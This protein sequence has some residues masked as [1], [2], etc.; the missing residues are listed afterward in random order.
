MHTHPQGRRTS[1]FGKALAN[2]SFSYREGVAQNCLINMVKRWLKVN[3]FSPM[4]YAALMDINGGALNLKTLS[5]IRTLETGGKKWVRNTLT[6]S[7]H[8]M[9]EAFKLTE[10]VG[11]ILAPFHIDQFPQGEAIRFDYAKLISLI[12][13]AFGIKDAALERNVAISCSI[14]GA[15]LTRFLSHVMG[16]FKIKDRAAID[17]LTKLP[18]FCGE[19]SSAQSR[20]LC[21]PMHLHMGQ[22]KKDK[23]TT[24]FGEMFDFFQR[25][26][27]PT[28]LTG[29]GDWRPFNLSINADM[30]AIW[31][32]LGRGGGARTNLRPCYCCAIHRDQQHIPNTKRCTRFCAGVEN[33]NWRCYHQVMVTDDRMLQMNEEINALKAAM[34]YLL[35]IVSSSRMTREDP[36]NCE[37]NETAKLDPYSIWFEPRKNSDRVDFSKLFNEELQIRGVMEPVG[38]LTSRREQL[39]EC[40]CREY[41]LRKLQEET[42]ASERPETAMF[43]LMQAVPCILHLENRVALKLLTMVVL[44]GISKTNEGLLFADVQ[45]SRERLSHYI[46]SIEKCMNETILGTVNSPAQWK[47]PYDYN[48]G[49]LGSITLEN[50]RVR[51]VMDQLELLVNLSIPD[52]NRKT[53][54]DR[55][56]PKY[57]AV[58]LQ[59]RCKVDWNTPENIAQFQLLVDEWFQDWIWLHGQGGITNYIHMLS[60]G[61]I[62]DYVFRW[63]NLYEHSQQGWESFNSLVKSFFFRRTG[64]GGGINRSRLRSIGRWLQRRAIWMC[65]YNEFSIKAFLETIDAG[66]QQEENF[67]QEGNDLEIAEEMEHEDNDEVF[68]AGQI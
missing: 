42:G 22:E 38:N 9:Q 44:E 64:H 21:F 40:L 20:L 18:I 3:F 10:R 17:P 43:L 13:S 41:R 15:N 29:L 19:A 16:G 28:S 5:L 23:Y 7:T 12:F 66:E 31:K 8:E 60:A 57:R 35:E 25:T 47:C 61:H 49:K 1:V 52:V 37:G 67:M 50:W 58:M 68:F 62:A 30:S 33:P 46:S 48:E 26:S 45:G 36:E 14:D 55:S 53:A 27:V 59:A 32:G 4:A 24:E 2:V 39:R 51:R 63:G 34:T 65:G 6:P 11:A 54:W 56:L